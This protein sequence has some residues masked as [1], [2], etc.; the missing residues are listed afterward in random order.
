[1][2]FTGLRRISPRVAAE[3]LDGDNWQLLRDYIV[4]W[5]EGEVVA[6]AGFITDFSSVPQ[7]VRSLVPQRGNQDGPA[8]IHDLCYR[9][10]LFGRATADKLYSK[11][12]GL[13][14]VGRGRRWA[15]YLGVRAGGWVSWNAY[16]RNEK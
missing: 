3:H 7:F 5:S 2:N 14:D 8:V 16:R 12:L 1:M 4:A 6:P 9:L 13:E 11:L 10:G 15:L